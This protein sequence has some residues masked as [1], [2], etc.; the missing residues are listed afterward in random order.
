MSRTWGFFL[1]L[2][3]LSLFNASAAEARRVEQM[4]PLENL[5][6]ADENSRDLPTL[7]T[8]SSIRGRSSIAS[9]I[10]VELSKVAKSTLT[11]NDWY[12]FSN[13]AD[14][15]EWVKFVL[16]KDSQEII[17]F[18]SNNNSQSDKDESGFLFHAHFLRELNGYESLTDN[19]I[20]QL[21]LY[22]E[23]REIYFGSLVVSSQDDGFLGIREYSFDIVGADLIPPREVKFVQEIVQRTASNVLPYPILPYAPTATQIPL[24]KG[25]E[26]EFAA[27]G[28]PLSITKNSNTEKVYALGWAAGTVLFI[29]DES[30][31]DRAIAKNR[32]KA[33]SILVLNYLP[34]KRLPPVAAIIASQRAN[35]QG[36]LAL[37]SKNLGI[38]FVYEDRAY[39]N[40]RWR[41]LSGKTIFVRTN[42]SYNKPSIEAFSISPETL[43]KLRVLKLAQRPP[44]TD[45][46]LEAAPLEILNF[47]EIDRDEI[48]KIGAKAANLA[49]M[50]RILAESGSNPT[51]TEDIQGH[52]IPFSFYL[53]HIAQK[54]ADGGET[55]VQLIEK[56]LHS[57]S[58]DLDDARKVAGELSKIRNAILTQSVPNDLLEKVEALALKL[59]KVQGIKKIRFRSSSNAED[60]PNFNGAGL[61]ESTGV[62][63]SVTRKDEER[64]LPGNS[65]YRVFAE[66]PETPN[67][68]VKVW[69]D[70]QVYLGKKLK[71]VWASLYSPEAYWARRR[72]NIAEENLAMGI[73]INRSFSNELARG[74]A[75]IR[76]KWG[77][78]FENPE[79]VITG[80]K[81]DENKVTGDTNPELLPEMTEVETGFDGELRV[82]V[83]RYSNVGVSGR[84]R[85]MESEQFYRD[86]YTQM[87]AVFLWWKTNP[88]NEDSSL[89][90]DFEWKLLPAENGRPERITLKQVRPLPVKGAATNGSSLVIANGSIT[91]YPSFGE[92]STGMENHLKRVDVSLDW[93]SVQFNP[94]K[95]ERLGLRTATL[96]WHDG[97]TETVKIPQ[98]TVQFRTT[99]WRKF[100][101]NEMSSRSVILSLQIPSV[102]FPSMELSVVQTQ[103][104]D[105]NLNI[106]SPDVVTF[107]DLRLHFNVKAAELLNHQK[108]PRCEWNNQPIIDSGW[109]GHPIEISVVGSGQQYTHRESVQSM[110]GGVRLEMLSATKNGGM[111]KTMFLRVDETTITGL[112]PGIALRNL[113]PQAV[114]YAPAHHNF[115]FQ[116]VF[117]LAMF[118]ENSEAERDAAMKAVG[119]RYLVLSS[120]MNFN[121]L[122]TSEILYVWAED[123]T[124]APYYIELD[125][126][127]WERGRLE[128]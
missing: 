113:D 69:Q 48:A 95:P 12:A 18:K 82:N 8:A 106:L 70:Y 59:A 40:D 2:L 49:Q 65:Q 20:D 99:E 100:G 93:D 41:D 109:F 6:R 61:Y 5:C 73:L 16:F 66:D 10:P 85:I 78:D 127:S 105:S 54:V 38:P 47:A 108:Y 15:V 29:Q 62:K 67:S 14:D 43:A 87:R 72:A 118:S 124:L 63:L 52:A 44:R 30:E 84:T 89:Q 77:T 35:E 45:L 96:R 74:V 46:I 19:T 71:Q 80:F 37:Y 91:L 39:F 88:A 51:I 31:L 111:D 128:R 79:L 33:D 115:S 13:D 104:A 126:N 103:E 123:G 102:R 11:Q 90:L 114:T 60:S 117:D 4:P 36:H 25:K 110:D 55:L 58:I 28:I 1:F 32:V 122:T 116:Y 112:V 75:V 21:T 22:A 57:A 27:L 3:S 107:Y 42:E 53:A 97:F 119:G 101:P 26:A 34:R 56:H 76:P 64:D 125:Q 92:G 17:F 81:G 121:D 83:R 68:E 50:V 24:V 94:E 23:S 7:A 86:L 98:D 9:R 120:G